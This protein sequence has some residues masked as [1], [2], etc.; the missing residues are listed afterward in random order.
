MIESYDKLIKEYINKEQKG[1]RHQ[2]NPISLLEDTHF[3]VVVDDYIT[4][5]SNNKIS[6][7]TNLGLPFSTCY[8]DF[9]IMKDRSDCTAPLGM[10]V[11]EVAPN[12]FVL[13]VVQDAPVKTRDELDSVLKHTLKFPKEFYSSSVYNN[14]V[15]SMI[16]ESPILMTEYSVKI[17]TQ[18]NEVTSHIITDSFRVGTLSSEDVLKSTFGYNSKDISERTITY[19]IVLLQYIANRQLTLAE[20]TEQVK[21]RTRIKGQFIKKKYKPN[22][23]IY[24]GSEKQVQKHA[25]STK[26]IQHHDFAWEVRGFWRQLASGHRIGHDRNGSVITNGFT[27][28]KPHT[29]GNGEVLKKV[30]IYK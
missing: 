30:R 26:I 21:I 23:I 6:A 4:K 27:W 18:T 10:L 9:S 8:F 14:I 16:S 15:D 3:F 29:R 24:I 1:L 17:N 20:N 19:F 5:V 25:P 28:V 2:I 12:D 22:Y 7:T 13:Q 11:T